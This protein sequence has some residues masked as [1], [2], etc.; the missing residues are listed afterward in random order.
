MQTIAKTSEDTANA[1]IEAL[2]TV[3]NVMSMFEELNQSISKTTNGIDTLSNQSNEISSVVE[4][5]KDIAEQTNLLALNAAIEAARAGEHGR[6]FAVVAD[7]VRK[8]AERT[9]K[10][11]QEISITITTLKQE[12][13]EIQNESETMY[14]LSNNSVEQM[15]QFSKT[16]YSFNEN[17]KKTADDAIKINNVFLI[18]IVKIDHS[19]LKSSAYSAIINCEKT[20]NFADHTQCKFGKW[21]KGE[22]KEIFG[23]TKAYEQI[24]Y[25]HKI[26]HSNILKSLEFIKSASVYEPENSNIIIKNFTE[27]EDA[28]EKFNLLLHEMIER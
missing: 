12:T 11:T 8:L 2:D 28:S 3:N 13:A 16:L 4:L 14:K 25:Y 22:G 19:I 18:S 21:Y 24:S 20:H 10:A 9:T 27:M 26:V 5:I 17:A 7:E 23:H 1:S 6:G 15:E